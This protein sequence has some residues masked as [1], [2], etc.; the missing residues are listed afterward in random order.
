MDRYQETLFNAQ[1]NFSHFII[2]SSL[3]GF[4]ED[5]TIPTRCIKSG[6]F[7]KISAKMKRIGCLSS[8]FLNVKT[9]KYLVDSIN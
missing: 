9:A 5:G 2:M 6:I 3:L 7:E 4:L 1:G 8:T